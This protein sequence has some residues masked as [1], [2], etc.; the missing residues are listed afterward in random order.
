MEDNREKPYR[1]PRH[2][3]R[4][5]VLPRPWAYPVEWRRLDGRGWLSRSIAHE[6][7]QRRLFPWIPV[8]FGIGIVLF[9]QADGQ[10]A[11]WAPFGAAASCAAAAV[12]LRRVQAV[13]IALIAIAALFA[14]FSA[15]AIRMRSV[16]APALSR[17]VVTPVTGFIESIEERPEGKRLL[18]HVVEM[19]NVPD[20]ERPERIRV[21]VRRGIELSPGQLM[22]GTA[23]L[24]P[25]SQPAWPGGYDFARD[26]YFKGIGAVGSMVGQIRPTASPPGASSA[27]TWALWLA[28]SVDAA[29]NAL[30]ER[31]ATSIG[32]AAGGVGAALVT[33]KRG[34]IPEQT[35][36]VL[37][38]A[39]IYHIVSISGLHM[40]L[41]AGTFFWLVR[42][43]LA[44]APGLAL[45]WP[46]KK[47]AAVAAM[48]GA[49]IY[50]IFSGSD[51][52]TERSLIMTLVMFGAVMAD[53]PALSI[54]NLSISALVVLAREPEAL[55]GPSF[56]MS[57]SAVAAMMA[58]VPLMHRR[59]P[60]GGSSGLVA[61]VASRAARPAFG[62]VT[63]TLVA[64]VATAPFAAYHFQ[65][66]NPYGLVGNAL[67]LPL[68]SL[69]AMPC[70]VLGVLA[71]PF[72]LDRPIWQLMGAAVS[73]VLDVSTWVGGFG[74][75][76]LVVPAL[77]SA[78]LVLLS[79]GL[80]LLALPASSLRWLAVVPA[81]VGLACAAVP[82]RYD[83]FIDRDGAGAAIR[84]RDSRLTLVG[85]PSRF[86]A[87]QWLRA[88]GD[89]RSVDDASLRRDARCDRAGCVVAAA[90]G[91]WIAFVQEFSAFEEDCRRAAVVVSR[92]QAPPGCKA[93]FV[94]D[95]GALKESGA[96]TIRFTPEA[97][98]VRSVRT[99]SQIR[100]WSEAAHRPELS[101]AREGPRRAQPIP[102]QDLPEE[103]VS[104]GEPD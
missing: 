7:D 35:N 104:T 37:R 56:Q 14:G 88:D 95:G 61:R 98:E 64:S 55:L 96:T 83:V 65:S 25:P 46:V 30:T 50:C 75:S 11:L 47:I 44:L 52:A 100:P 81:G 80:I 1:I 63:T 51:V 74:G 57:F 90:G 17:I 26:A 27:P 89:A 38:G 79:V 58:L 102:E 21:S 45:S 10:P 60:D 91:R 31:I 70:A 4:A 59:V 49:T 92:L 18:L 69:V 73:Q 16:A 66:L 76:T 84:G 77:G 87:E 40:V 78:S 19:R 6:M 42:A 62:L 33:G 9:F 93:G 15:G 22:T 12:A 43:L 68:V 36:A 99:G 32:G 72:G 34:L 53:R 20:A 85:R 54:R 39:G 101:P 8:F 103:G 3:A 24:L 67:A 86:I 23:R 2:G 71:Y 82:Y 29:R 97:V 94:W 28:A 48:V 5:V 41:A 13:S